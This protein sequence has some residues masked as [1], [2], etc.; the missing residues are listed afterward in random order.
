MQT[1][2]ILPVTQAQYLGVT[3]DSCLSL[4][5]HI[6]QQIL[7][8][9]PSILCQT[10]SLLTGLIANILVQVTTTLEWITS[11]VTYIW[12]CGVSPDVPFRIKA[13]GNVTCWEPHQKCPQRQ[14]ASPRAMT[15]PQGQPHPMTGPHGLQGWD[16][17]SQFRTSLKGHLGFR[18]P[19]HCLRT[20]VC[21]CHSSTSPCARSC[22]PRCLTGVALE[23]TSQQA[24]WK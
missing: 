15:P 12:F 13:A 3:F 20:L 23:S 8:V 9:L 7:L 5:F 4:M 17:L 6:H 1:Q 16:P 19:W 22:L 10:Q 24:F 2:S 11:I 21:L 14:T 18:F